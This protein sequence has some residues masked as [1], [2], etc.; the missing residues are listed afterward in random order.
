M[1]IIKLLEILSKKP[2]GA[3]K[4]EIDQKIIDRMNEL[5]ER[6]RMTSDKFLN[7]L[8]QR[9]KKA[10]DDPNNPGGYS[11]REVENIDNPFD[12]LEGYTTEFLRR[13]LTTM[14]NS[15]AFYKKGIKSHRKAG[16]KIE[17]GEISNRKAKAMLKFYSDAVRKLNIEIKQKTM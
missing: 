4:V 16:G 15:L 5:E 12:D 17:R 14:K 13:I 3:D 11:E 9:T 1:K 6:K 2:E 7:M 10:F 8:T